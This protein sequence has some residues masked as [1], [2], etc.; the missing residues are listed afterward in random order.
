MKNEKR[1]AIKFS[2]KPDVCPQCG[3]KVVEIIYGLPTYETF[4]ASKRGEVMLGGCVV[5]DEAAD[6]QCNKCGQHYIKE[7]ND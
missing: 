2:E 4:E 1:I 3:G 5:Y 6:W 7:S